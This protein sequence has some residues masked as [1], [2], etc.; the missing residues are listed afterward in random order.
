[1]YLTHPSRFDLSGHVLATVAHSVGA[2]L[3]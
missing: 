1:V 2:G 3:L